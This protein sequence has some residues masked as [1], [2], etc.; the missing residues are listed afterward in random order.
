MGIENTKV[1]IELKKNMTTHDVIT[2]SSKGN[3]T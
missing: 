2:Y 3:V 1:V